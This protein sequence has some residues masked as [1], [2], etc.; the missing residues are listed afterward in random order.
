MKRF[1][2]IRRL[3]FIFFS[4]FAVTLAG[5]FVLQ[6]F[7]VEPGDRCTAKGYWYDMETRIC[8]QPVYLP[9]ITK[10]PEGMT[11]AEAS[12]EANRDLV[13]LEDQIAADK[14][15]RAAATEAERERVKALQGR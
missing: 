11:R 1:L 14:R 3:S 2:T 7:W 15:A 5:L 13:K 6:R 4:L 8:A 9:D 10:R 12:A